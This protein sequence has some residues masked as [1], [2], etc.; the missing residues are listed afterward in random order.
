MTFED[1]WLTRGITCNKFLD[2]ARFRMN[3][4]FCPPFRVFQFLWTGR[5]GIR[6][7]RAFIDGPSL[8]LLYFQ[9]KLSTMFHSRFW[10]KVQIPSSW[11]TCSI[12]TFHPSSNLWYI[13]QP[14]LTYVPFKSNQWKVIF[15]SIS[16]HIKSIAN[17]FY[18]SNSD[19]SLKQLNSSNLKLYSSIARSS[20][21]HISIK[22]GGSI[23]A[24]I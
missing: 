14:I 7:N 13:Y 3:F 17:L 10:V 19:Y 18:V 15:N 8:S 16:D 11:Q 22:S 21:C 2:W 12:P 24:L 5:T 23:L 1:L 4:F 20:L 6:A 9:F